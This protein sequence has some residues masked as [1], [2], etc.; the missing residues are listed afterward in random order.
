MDCGFG[1]ASCCQPSVRR[2]VKAPEAA[3]SLTL[4]L[5]QSEMLA[6]AFQASRP[7]GTASADWDARR[8]RDASGILKG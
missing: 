1:G 5:Q 8:D 3:A 4:M 7:S 2:N 6:C